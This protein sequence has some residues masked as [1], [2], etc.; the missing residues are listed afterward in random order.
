MEIIRSI[1]ITLT[2]D[3]N[4]RTVIR[5]CD[6]PTSVEAALQWVAD[7]LDTLTE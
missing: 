7:Q 6:N 4:K 3:T 2:V 5:Q 1:E